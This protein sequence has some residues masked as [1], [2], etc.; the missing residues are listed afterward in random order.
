MVAARSLGASWGRTM[1][2]LIGLLASTGMRVGEAIHLDVTDIDWAGG[3]LVVRST[4]FGKSREVVLQATTAEALRTYRDERHC[5]ASQLRPPRSSFPLSVTVSAMTAFTRRSTGLSSSSDCRVSL[6]TM[7]PGCTTSATPSSC[8]RC[9]TGTAAAWTSAGACTCS[10]PTWATSIRPRR[11]GTCRRRQSSW[12][13]PQSDS[14]P[15]PETIRERP[16]ADPA[17]LLHRPPRQTA[18]RQST[19]TRG[20]PGHLSDAADVLPRADRQNTLGTRI[21]RSR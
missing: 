8:A 7:A 2:T 20:L 13:W 11:I 10:R 18:G 15:T 3:L 16:G 14:N 19:Y 4:K 9:S 5:R 17:G 1:E 6:N 12:R 21:R